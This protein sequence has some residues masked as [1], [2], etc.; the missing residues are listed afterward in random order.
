MIVIDPPRVE[1]FRG[2]RV[3]TAHLVST[4][5]GEAGTRE[6]VDFAVRIGM[7]RDWIQHAGTYREHFDLIGKARCAAAIE[8]GAVVDRRALGEALRVKREAVGFAVGTSVV[9]PSPNP[10]SK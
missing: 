8:A 2:R 7:R 3:T 4:L 5:P 6:L 10:E 1:A 9:T